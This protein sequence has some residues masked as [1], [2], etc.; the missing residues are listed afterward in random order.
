[1]KKQY[2]V[3]L[4]FRVGKLEDNDFITDEFC[5]ADNYRDAVRIAKDYSMKCDAC[6]VICYCKTA[7][8][9][10]CQIF[11]ETYIKGKKLRRIEF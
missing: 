7:E 3:A 9:D 2:E 4:M 1:M 6:D 8:T 5:D 11:R 10:Y